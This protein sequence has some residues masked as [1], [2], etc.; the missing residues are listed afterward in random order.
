MP[1]YSLEFK[2]FLNEKIR[3]SII[4]DKKKFTNRSITNLRSEY[5]GMSEVKQWWRGLADELQADIES[6]E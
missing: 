1:T 2:L 5:L 6:E 3:S 4:F